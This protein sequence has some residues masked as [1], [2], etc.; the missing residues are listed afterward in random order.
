MILSLSPQIDKTGMAHSLLLLAHILF[1]VSPYSSIYTTLLPVYSRERRNWVEQTRVTVIRKF[2]YI[3]KGRS[4]KHVDTRVIS[5]HKTSSRVSTLWPSIQQHTCIHILKT[6]FV[7]LLACLALLLPASW[8][9]FPAQSVVYAANQSLSSGLQSNSITRSSA[10]KALDRSYRNQVIGLFQQAATHHGLPVD[11]L[12]AIAW[13][14]SGW[15]QNVVSR[16]GGIGIMQ[17]MPGTA[18]GLNTQAHTHY[19]PYKLADNI[20]LGATYLH[21]LWKGFHGNLTKVISAYNEGGWNVV[22]RGI[23]NWRYVNNVQ[24]LMRR[25]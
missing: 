4:M 5:I 11:L 23:F 12:E 13:Q 3:W 17:L 14:E 15:R 24:A 9:V 10:Y 16:D 7:A 6:R 8:L 21:S 18:S 2:S 20:A 1:S 25:F 22:H 19:N